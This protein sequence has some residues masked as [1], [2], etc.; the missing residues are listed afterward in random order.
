MGLTK[1][2]VVE[3]ATRQSQRAQLV[4]RSLRQAGWRERYAGR[5][6]NGKGMVFRESTSE[7]RRAAILRAV[8]YARQVEQ[9]ARGTLT[10]LEAYARQEGAL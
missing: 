2:Y 9:E 4:T 10:V 3:V 5:S 6:E 1:G 7:D 8:E